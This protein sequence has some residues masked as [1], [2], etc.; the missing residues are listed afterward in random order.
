MKLDRTLKMG[1]VGGGPGAFIGDV[2]RK[3]ARL[4]G[5]IEIVAGAFDINPRKSRSMAK[6][7]CIDKKR[8]YGDYKEMIEKEL[9]L[10]VGER[11]DFVTICTPNNWHFPIA[12]DFINAG[13]HVMCE[14]P[15]TFN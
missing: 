14:K 3:A 2:H 15:M 8:A 1:M 4:D 10:P 5:G 11:I 9:A 13:F 6:E 7:L 12:R